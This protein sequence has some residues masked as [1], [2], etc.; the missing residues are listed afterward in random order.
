M[1]IVGSKEKA[2]A[3]IDVPEEKIEDAVNE[4]KKRYKHVKSILLKLGG[5]EGI[6]R[7]YSTK[8]IWGD[9][10]TEVIHKEYGYLLKLD[11]LRVYFSPREAEERKRISKLIKPN[12]RVLV[13]FSGVAPFAI[14]IA[15]AQPK[16]SE[17]VCVDINLT[18]VQYAE[19]NVKL[20]K[21]EGK[22]KNYCWDV[23]EATGLGKF[24]RILMP[25][26]ESAYQFLDVAYKVAKPKAIVHLYGI[27]EKSDFS[28]LKEKIE[29]T[30]KRF[31]FKIKILKKQKVSEYAPYKWKV[32]F[33]LMFI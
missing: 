16:V 29:E 24:D 31:G 10:N 14:A 2:V 1:D 12:E 11:P 6:Y 5:R 33:D 20:N 30:A 8:L 28:D 25:L 17:I 19:E 4:I 32:R 7:I 13:M 21:L 9:S 22:I 18:A 27:S 23:R 15:K 26:P 3:I